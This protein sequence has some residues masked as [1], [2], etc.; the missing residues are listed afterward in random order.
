PGLSFVARDADRVVGAV[1][2]GQDGRRGY[3]HHLTVAPS[4]RGGGLGR[5]LC[6]RCLD[7]LRVVGIE[8]C[9]VFV[10][11]DNHDAIAFWRA[12]GWQ[13]RTDLVMFSMSTDEQTSPPGSERSTG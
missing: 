1:L 11:A 5:T 10:F 8:K 4:H 3:L 7:A 2:C 13:R 12:A 6:G 9:H